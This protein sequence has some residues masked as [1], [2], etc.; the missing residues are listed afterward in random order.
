M[1]HQ[2]VSTIRNQVYTILKNNICSGSYAPG[3]WL[4]EKELTKNLCV[5]RSPVREAL[6]QLAVDGLIVEIPNKGVFVK[7]FSVK[8]MEEIFDVRVLLENHAIDCL[9]SRLTTTGKEQLLECKFK[10]ERSHRSGDLQQYIIEDSQLHCLLVELSENA[11]LESM[12]TRV[13][14][15]IHQFRIYSLISNKRFEESLYEHSEVIHCI[16]SGDFEEAKSINYRH[17]QLARDKIIEHLNETNK[18]T[19]AQIK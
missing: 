7:E 1:K 19:A 18:H 13:L 11:L 3:Q 9:K 10:L 15:M 16:L 8:D 5:S 6:R 17:L 14:S 4:L 12:Y 2:P